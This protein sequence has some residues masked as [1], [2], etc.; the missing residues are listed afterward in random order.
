MSTVKI[1]KK[2]VTVEAVQWTGDNE[3]ELREFTRNGFDPFRMES[4]WEYQVEDETMT[5]VVFDYLHSRWVP[6]Q[7]GDWV[8]QGVKG[9]FYPCSARV[10]DETYDRLDPQ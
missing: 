9:E 2:P 8:I 1:R 4:R 5:A 3:D 7:T 6:L 10:I